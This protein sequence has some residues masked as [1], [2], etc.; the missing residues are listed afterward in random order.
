M[1][2]LFSTILF[3]FGSFVAAQP[4]K[5]T[6]VVQDAETLQPLPGASVELKISKQGVSTDAKGSFVLD[7][8]E[9]GSYKLQISYI[10]YLKKEVH[11]NLQAD[12]SENLQIVLKP[13]PIKGREVVVVG[14]RAV[15]GETPAAFSTVT[16]EEIEKRYFVQDIP[17][18]LSELPSTTYYSES[19]NGVGYNYL[20]IRGFGQRRI[21][22][23]I[24][25]I[26]QNDPEDH[27]VYWLDFP[28]LLGNV[29]DV[30]VQRGAGSAFYGPPAI[31]GSVNI[32]TSQ[33]SQEARLNGYAGYGGY[34]TR[35]F[36]LEVNSGL[37]NNQF[38]LYGRGSRIQSDGYRDRSW[39]D[40][41]SYFIGAARFGKNSSTRLHFY[42]GP[43]EDHLAYYGI[44]KEMALDRDSRRENPIQRADEIEN[45]NQP[46]LELIHEHQ[47]SDNIRLN[48]TLFGIRGYGF[49]DYDGSW[50]PMSYYRL[51]PQYG[52]DVAGNP[53]NIYVDSLLIRAYVDN[54][55][56]GWMPQLQW[57][58]SRGKLIA[59]SEI[60]FHR[61]LHWG[62]I[63]NAGSGMPPAIEG[64]YNGLSYIGERRYYEYRGAKDIISPYLHTTWQFDRKTSMMLDLQFAY[65]KYR[66]FDE[67]FLSTDFSLQYYFLNPRAGINYKLT[68][69]INTFFS[70]SRTRREPRLKN[71]YDAA[72]A[73]TPESWGAVV[74]Q[75]ETF[76]DGT[77]NFDEPLVTPET[78]MDYELGLNYRSPDFTAG[79]NLFYMDFYD[80][81]IKQGQLDRF[82]QPVTG[83]ADRTRHA[84]AEFYFQGNI[85][86]SF[87]LS[88][89]FTYSQNKLL[90]YYVFEGNTRFNLDGNTIAGFPDMLANLRATYRHRS[91]TASLV[92]RHVGK[93]F[94]DNFENEAN[95][96]DAYTVF[97]GSLGYD[98]TA[99]PGLSL[100]NLQLHVRNIFDT[101][102]IT[103]GEGDQFFPAAERH[104]FV[105]ARFEL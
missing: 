95:T 86:R 66:L 88:G 91:F 104:L 99:L 77:Y 12:E 10:G 45:F 70:V 94:T 55:Q 52:F 6:G 35:K 3:L 9:A 27:N 64:A 81:I 79:M 72:E 98:I 23:M 51:T 44:S 103:H 76:A 59:G 89:N 36:S 83:N 46:H 56:I 67:K 93:Q 54:R 5:I 68:P 8:L 24:N 65:N 100:L 1:I 32:I 47:L 7:N 74:P 84:G 16:S 80:E 58:H 96:V 73:S 13:S 50:A 43:V 18:L 102:Y 63:Q 82:G 49:F 14:T 2:R 69:H 41:K 75:F 85:N 92:M 20:S 22:V 39:S 11:V 53:E 57:D 15:E 25:G 17:V 71:F 30:Q 38:V 42:G 60:R 40:F 26:P 48:N 87:I 37:L 19:G 4:A 28:D 29:Q 34:N 97:H 78:L 61:S 21:S 105:N 31:G 90:D 62:R 33:F 101:L